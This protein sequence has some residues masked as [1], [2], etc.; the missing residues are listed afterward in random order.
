MASKGNTSNGPDWRDVVAA[1]NAYGRDWDAFVALHL[2]PGGTEK[3][4]RMTV[5]AAVYTEIK[6]VGVAKPLASASVLIPGSSA[7][8]ISA[9]ALSALYELDKEMYRMTTGIS[10]IRR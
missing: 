3:S 5:V 8:G 7:G 1:A 6:D 10:P 4:P 9:A 2:R